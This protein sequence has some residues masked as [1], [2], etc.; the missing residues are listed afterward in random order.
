MALR[1]HKFEL[2]GIVSWGDG[3][4]DAKKPG[5]YTRVNNTLQWIASQ[6]GLSHT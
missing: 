6:T 3:C 4:A 5:V 1:D 2:A